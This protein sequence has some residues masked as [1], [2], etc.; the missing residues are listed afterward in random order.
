MITQT[1]RTY[2]RKLHVN[3]YIFLLD[4]SYVLDGFTLS[5]AWRACPKTQFSAAC[6]DASSPVTPQ[7]IDLTS[8]PY[9]WLS[10]YSS[11]D[12]IAELTTWSCFVNFLLCF[13]VQLRHDAPSFDLSF[14]GFHKLS[15]L[16]LFFLCPFLVSFVFSHHLTQMDFTFSLITYI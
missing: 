2:Q 11:R 3:S 9:E 12:C 13:F 8:F 15:L 5:L 10:N 7:S 4:S 1:V 6:T 16:F 14:R